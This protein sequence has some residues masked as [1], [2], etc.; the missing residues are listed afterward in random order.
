M[1]NMSVD[2]YFSVSLFCKVFKASDVALHTLQNV[3]I[4]E[5]PWERL[6]IKLT[7]TAATRSPDVDRLQLLSPPACFPHFPACS[8]HRLTQS[9]AG[10]LPGICVPVCIGG[11]NCRSSLYATQ[12]HP[13]AAADTS[14]LKWKTSLHLTSDLPLI[15][16]ST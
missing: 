15:P 8:S 11:L 1:Q 10:C 9:F 6:Y 12:E 7:F 14:V 3:G 5:A 13:A 2:V 4:M 16:I